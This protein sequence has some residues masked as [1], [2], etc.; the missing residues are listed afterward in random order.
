M[1]G[2][3]RFECYNIDF[4]RWLKMSYR[5]VKT[6]KITWYSLLIYLFKCSYGIY[7]WELDQKVQ[8]SSDNLNA[9][10]RTLNMYMYLY[11]YFLD[12][13]KKSSNVK[14]V[15]IQSIIPGIGNIFLTTDTAY[16]I[17]WSSK[18]MKKLLS[19][20]WLHKW[21]GNSSSGMWFSNLPVQKSGT[22]GR[23][24]SFVGLGYEHMAKAAL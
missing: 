22:I 19:E 4:Q 24:T 13:C 16:T 10:Q 23:L 18:S 12:Q 15:I 3:L 7:I 20:S 5:S 17:F 9:F 6:S 8:Y 14:Y 1:H 2:S 11:I 21:H